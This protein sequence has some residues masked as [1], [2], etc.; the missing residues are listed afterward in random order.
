MSDISVSKDT[1]APKKLFSGFFYNLNY[2]SSTIFGILPTLITWYLSKDFKIMLIVLT[3]S[4]SATI[5]STIN[6]N[7]KSNEN[8]IKNLQIKLDGYKS[9]VDSLKNNLDAKTNEIKKLKR[10]LEN[11]ESNRD[12]ILESFHIYQNEAQ[13]YKNAYNSAKNGMI[14]LSN[15]QKNH[16]IKDSIKILFENIEKEQIER[17]ESFERCI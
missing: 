4:I 8:L 3:I 7:S 15:M 6:K 2:I 13:I 5:I 17:D 12:T 14:V 11:T 10:D 1:N 9:E 16:T